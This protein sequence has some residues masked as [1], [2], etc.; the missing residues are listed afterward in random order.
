MDS[1]F[2]LIMDIPFHMPIT[3]S[4]YFSRIIFIKIYRF[5]FKTAYIYNHIFIL[6]NPFKLKWSLINEHNSN[7]NQGV[8]WRD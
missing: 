8:D 1:L 3:I 6:L 2:L 5:L 4:Y 7:N